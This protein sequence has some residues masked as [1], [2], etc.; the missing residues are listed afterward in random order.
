MTSQ[1]IQEQLRFQTKDIKKK[2]EFVLGDL[3]KV[4]PAVKEAQQGKIV[5]ILYE[6]V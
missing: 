6:L 3:A 2:R 1:E 5:S 4:E